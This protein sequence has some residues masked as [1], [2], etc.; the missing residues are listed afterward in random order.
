L[1]EER[2]RE[3]IQDELADWHIQKPPVTRN[4]IAETIPPSSEVPKPETWL[5]KAKRLG[6]PTHQETGGIRKKGDV[7][8]D[9]EA[10]E[11]IEE[12]P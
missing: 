10:A 5:Q 1:G 4:E 8:A 7:L 2:I 3:I 12:S 11:K 6:V 9:I